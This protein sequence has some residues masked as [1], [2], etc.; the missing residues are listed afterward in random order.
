VRQDERHPASALDTG[1]AQ[2]TGEIVD[3]LGELPEGESRRF[4]RGGQGNPLAAGE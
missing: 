3:G 4:V 1:S 2:A